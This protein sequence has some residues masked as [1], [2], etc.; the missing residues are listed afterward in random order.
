M[1]LNAQPNF[2]PGLTYENNSHDTSENPYQWAQAEEVGAL[3]NK[4]EQLRLMHGSLEQKIAT[5]K[6][7]IY[8]SKLDENNPVPLSL[9]HG[10][11]KTVET[12]A[13]QKERGMIK[14]ENELDRGRVSTLVEVL[15]LYRHLHA[16]AEL[17]I[18]LYPDDG[19]EI[20]KFLPTDAEKLVIQKNEDIKL[21]ADIA[22]QELKFQGMLREFRINLAQ[23]VYN[24]RVAEFIR[25]KLA[26]LEQPISD[27]TI[28]THAVQMD[29]QK[30]DSI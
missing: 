20:K 17:L 27:K 9:W 25:S 7:K 16:D 4:I 23:E 21:M 1:K 11:D 13:W 12:A 22:R 10:Y 26:E 2:D 24:P 28:E 6:V 19:D 30:N 5:T 8:G 29:N 18:S 3:K 14:N 15:K